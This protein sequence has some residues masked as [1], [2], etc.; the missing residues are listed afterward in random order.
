[1]KNKN[2]TL[3]QKNINESL[4]ATVRVKTADKLHC[5]IFQKKSRFGVKKNLN[6]I[7]IN[8][9]YD[10]IDQLIVQYL[11][12]DVDRPTDVNLKANCFIYDINKIYKLCKDIDRIYEAYTLYLVEKQK[13]GNARIKQR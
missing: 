11:P 6:D 9:D 1:M 7:V 13:Q 2:S 12:D 8:F 3:F 10:L 4:R 5:V